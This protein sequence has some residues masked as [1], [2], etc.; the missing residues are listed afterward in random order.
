MT[1]EEKQNI[2]YEKAMATCKKYGYTLI[3]KKEEMI[4]QNIPVTYICPIHGERTIKLYRL[5]VGCEC[6]KCS[7]FSSASKQ[8][9]ATLTKRQ[10]SIYTRC[11]EECNKNGYKLITQKEEIKNNTTRMVYKCPK[12]GMKDMR[13]NN[14][15]NGKCCPACNIEQH[16]INYRLDIDEVERRICECGGILLNK[17]DYINSVTEN[18]IILCPE[19]KTPFTTSLVKYTQHGGQVCENCFNTESMGEK[20]IRYYLER[21]EIKFIQQKWFKDCRDINP[22]PF[23]FYLPD[24]NTII[25]FD[26]RQHFSETNFFSYSYEKTKKHDEIKNNYCNI[27]NIDIIRIPYWKIN[28]IDIILDKALNLHEDIA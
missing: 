23:D 11:L 25:E 5:L 10:E 15:M 21:N 16:S 13:A 20:K 4:N 24:I 14:M 28:N 12:H 9:S 18:L 3:T 17:E 27:N 2:Y 1:L 19:C 8:H 7:R 6:Y 22:L 26:G